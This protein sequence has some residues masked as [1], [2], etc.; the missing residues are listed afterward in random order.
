FSQEIHQADV[1]DLEGKTKL[2]TYHAKR[3]YDKDVMSFEAQFKDA[4]TGEVV[5]NEKAQIKNGVIEHYEVQRMATKDSGVIEVKDGKLLFT[6][7]DAG[8]KSEGKEPLKDTTLISATLVPYLESKFNDLLAKKDVDF[9]YA[10]WYRKETVGF[11]FSFDKEENDQVVIKMNPTNFLY[12]SLVNPIYF[13]YKKSTKK[14]L[15]IKGRTLPKQ[16]VGSAWK[17]VDALAIYK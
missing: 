9:R 13:T 17:D 5:A 10:V 8:K 7:N 12:K 16:K 4:T 6:Y 2:F 1:F 15:S 14:L 11:R 3:T